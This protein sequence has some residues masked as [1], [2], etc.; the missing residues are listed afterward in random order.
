MKLNRKALLLAAALPLMLLTACAKEISITVKNK[1]GDAVSNLSVYRNVA[2][3]D[4]A[5]LSGTLAD[6]A[7]TELT[8]GKF[9]EEE[10]ENGFAV[11]VGE[12]LL[13]GE[14]ASAFR[15]ADGD[16]L[17]LYT[18]AYGLQGAVNISGAELEARIKASEAQIS[19][20]DLPDPDDF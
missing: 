3:G 19:R 15:F 12:T 7:E 17:T 8:L 9:T 6:G 13:I 14:Y 5:G 1:T 20:E 11:S 2:D 4:G 18:D 16:I 10:L